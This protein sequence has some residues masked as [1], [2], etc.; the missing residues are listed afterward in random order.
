MQDEPEPVA[1]FSYKMSPQARLGMLKGD[2]QHGWNLVERLFAAVTERCVRRGSHTAVRKL[3]KDTLA[4]RKCHLG[5]EGT[6]A[7]RLQNQVLGL[8]SP[9]ITFEKHEKSKLQF[10]NKE[11]CRIGKREVEHSCPWSG[12]AARNTTF[13]LRVARSGDEVRQLAVWRRRPRLPAG[14]R[15]AVAVCFWPVRGA[16]WIRDNTP[17]RT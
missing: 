4:Y 5:Q 6:G 14:A 15:D 11:S 17:G 7:H 3:Q 13:R 12:F 1:G 2:R 9:G 16:F 8:S 10:A